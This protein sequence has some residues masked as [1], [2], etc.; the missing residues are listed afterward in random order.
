MPGPTVGV[1]VAGASMWRKKVDMLH[2]GAVLSAPYTGPFFWTLV[3]S[4]LQPEA[5]RQGLQ[6]T[7]LL[8]SSA[9]ELANAI[10]ALLDLRVGAI[11]VKPIHGG[12]DE[13]EPALGRA[14]AQGVPIIT[15]DS[16]IAHAAVRATVGSDNFLG[17]Q[18]ATRHAL[19]LLGGRGRVVYF[20]GD[21]RL[22]AGGARNLGFREVLAQYPDVEL[23]QV[24][25]LDWVSPVSRIDMSSR[26]MWRVLD[27]HDS[28]DALIAAGD[29][30][31]IGGINAL[32]E[33]MR[34]KRWQGRWP[35]IVGFNGLAE[36][37]LL[38][39]SGDMSATIAQSPE[40]LARTA[41]EMAAT[42]SAEASHAWSHRF[43][44]SELVTR[45]N[46][47]EYAYR[48][49]D[50][51]PRFI[52]E[53]GDSQARERQ[54]QAEVISRQR[55]ALTVIS[56]ASA[57]LARK[58][59]PEQM[60]G[61]LYRLLKAEF[62]HLHCEVTTHPSTPL[63][64][65][66]DPLPGRWIGESDVFH[67]TWAWRMTGD[68]VGC[69]REALRDDA[70][71]WVWDLSSQR[72]DSSDGD[73]SADPWSPERGSSLFTLAAN[74]R[75]YGVMEVRGPSERALGSELVQI[76]GAIAH[77]LSLAF[78]AAALHE[79]TAHLA[80]AELRAAQEKLVHAERAEYLA[81]HDPLTGLANRRRFGE[82]LERTLAE[83]ARYERQF[84]LY[85]L[86]LDGFKRINDSLGHEAGDQL[87]LQ[88]ANRLRGVLRRTDTVARLG[89]DEFMVLV[90]ELQDE[91]HA[92]MVASKLVSAFDAAFNLGDQG[93]VAST[94]VGAAVFPLHGNEVAA[95]MRAADTAMYAAKRAGK[96]RFAF[97]QV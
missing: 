7:K 30:A 87:L 70:Q 79:E 34:Q 97:F 67:K 69:R 36:A 80:A 57:A 19:D 58:Q 1:I 44:D 17:M 18:R 68:P 73:S 48:F 77:Q 13:L 3:A 33:A 47:S 85:F 51:V 76:L 31:A 88:V 53:L 66:V 55:S 83:A 45:D 82:V 61:A 25:P 22:S 24:E 20:A 59:S 28:F 92:G 6:L 93:V 40:W 65:T 37:L 78:E 4:C 91:G 23:L 39:K 86:D 95:L 11:V 90:P 35:V 12:G 32:R 89:G 15:L 56:A 74:G 64:A 52:A 94:S 60:V 84:A 49:L 63:D 14:H 96:N 9:S 26:C 50:L 43:V 75:A 8:A 42:C 81:N 16:K 29:E 72:R 71:Q 54:L 5:A 2:V 10:H 46:V 21:E 27:R 62:P 38:V 41:L